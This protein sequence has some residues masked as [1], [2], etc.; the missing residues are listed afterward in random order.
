M[1]DKQKIAY[2]QY[3]LWIISKIDRR[4]D[5]FLFA[6]K[7]TQELGLFFCSLEA[8]VTEF[9]AGINKSEINVLQMFSAG[10]M[11]EALSKNQGT[12]HNANT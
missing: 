8:S 6:G 10:V 12:F 5:L 7:R 1:K 4:I 9:G 3:N 2:C 11:H